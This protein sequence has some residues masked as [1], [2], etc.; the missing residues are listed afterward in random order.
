MA[1]LQERENQ[2]GNL[3]FI[4]LLPKYLPW[5][6]WNRLKTRAQNSIQVSHMEDRCPST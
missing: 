3:S 5:P 2:V 4:D 6:D 1:K